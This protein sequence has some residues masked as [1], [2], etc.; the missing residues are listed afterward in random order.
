MY[1]EKI[2]INSFGK[3]SGQEITLSP[4]V[5]VFEGENESGKSTAAAFIKFVLYGAKGDPAER[6]RYISW[7]G[8]SASGS[9]L[10]VD[11][12]RRITVER[13]VAVSGAGEREAF[14]ETVRMTDADTGIEIKAG[15]CPGEFLFGVPEDVFSGTAYVRQL[16]GA[17]IDGGRMSAATE[18]LLFSA[19]EAVNTE[20]AAARIDVLRRSLLH[21]NGKGGI[22]FEKKAKRDE[23]ASMLETAKTTSSEL[24]NVEASISELGKKCEAALARRDAA[25]TESAELDTLLTMRRFDRLRA[26]R[27]REEELRL[28]LSQESGLVSD[29]GYIGELRAAADSMTATS[30]SI[31]AAS[32]QLDG[33]RSEA[34]DYRGRERL[35][36]ALLDDEDAA[37]G[38]IEKLEKLASGK[39]AAAA[40]SAVTA[41]LAVVTAA[42]T[43]L[44]FIKG[45]ATSFMLAAAGTLG[46]AAIVSIAVYAVMEARC[47]RELRRYG[48]RD[49]EG[50]RAALDEA[51]EDAR[52]YRRITERI[53]TAETELYVQ[54]SV[55][56]EEKKQA[57][58]LLSRVG[59]ES[60]D[61]GLAQA[62]MGL[63]TGCEAA[64]TRVRSLTDEQR[65]VRADAEELE[66]QLS[67]INEAEIRE[68]AEE[69]SK[70]GRGEYD[71]ARVTALGKERE[72]AENAYQTL[73]AKIHELEVRRAHLMATRLDPAAI[74]V[75]LDELNSELAEDISRFDA[76][77][78][79][80][81]ALAAA[82][83]GVR[84]S[85][86]PRLREYAR[87]YM[88]R[89]TDGK[90]SEL[91][92]DAEFGMSVLADGTYRDIGLLSG[93]TVEAAYLS[94]RLALV[95]LLYR[96]STPPLVFDES[97]SQMD[98]TRAS[99]ML[100][101]IAGCG[102]QSLIMSCQGRETRLL[103]GRGARFSTV[104][105]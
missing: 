36:G 40:V 87:E 50:A 73:T 96:K 66:K 82:G 53:A 85:V 88:G 60:D 55:F 8:T 44:P 3:L 32:K 58:E 103:E 25:R 30:A 65:R 74:S 78:L 102:M 76:C 81:D 86:A 20:K 42:L 93:G 17:K 9:L 67:G 48:A 54:Y 64:L 47:R 28:S 61:E 15:D 62:L 79:A 92:V 18:N 56:D 34:D 95:K 69:L 4:G 77:V 38:M 97:F 6:R 84:E 33:L 51:E 23:L 13:T 1:I 37:D 26:Y 101:M 16:E 22:I 12:E 57:R 99:A 90:Y 45:I 7:G 75:K 14:R 72:L 46:A 59:I 71:P 52:E 43:L 100:E 11:G 27:E 10:V 91:G 39:T 94:L 70:L 21:K 83:R 80:T 105:M 104:R 98:D 68:K 24:I 5:N 19:D 41:V 49:M 29:E 2:M 35:F 89:V 63:I 31:A